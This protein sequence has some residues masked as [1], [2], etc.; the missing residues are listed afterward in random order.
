MNVTVL[1]VASAEPVDAASTADWLSHSLV[2][3]LQ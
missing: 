3:R 2:V 1:A